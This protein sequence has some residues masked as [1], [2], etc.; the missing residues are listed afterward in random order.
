[1]KIKKTRYVYLFVCLVV[2]ICFTCTVFFTWACSTGLA[3]KFHDY[4]D[5]VLYASTRVSYWRFFLQPP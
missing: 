2:S 1:M 4:L 5:L 3:L